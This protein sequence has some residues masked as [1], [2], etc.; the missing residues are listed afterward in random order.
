MANENGYSVKQIDE[1]TW[2]IEEHNYRLSVFCYLLEGEKKAM[3]I[4]SALGNIDLGGIVRGLTDK[5]VAVINTHP[6]GDHI[7][8]NADFTEIYISKEDQ[9][10]YA[11]DAGG[12]GPGRLPR[13]VPLETIGIE[14]G[15]EFDLGGRTL[16]VINTP[17]HS[18]GS[19]SILDVERRLLYT[20]DCCCRGEILAFS[21]KYGLAGYRD[22]MQ[23]ILDMGDQFDTTWPAH[24]DTPVGKDV[25]QRILNLAN[26]ILDGKLEEKDFPNKFFGDYKCAYSE[27]LGIVYPPIER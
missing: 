10:G 11:R 17:G 24:C 22:T 27:E 14:E 6:H 21:R 13:P 1:H 23:K 3:L 16:R 15:Q 20:G 4:D 9:E 2:Q 19:I 18:D 8:G 25:L 12:K 7:G 5:P 26:D